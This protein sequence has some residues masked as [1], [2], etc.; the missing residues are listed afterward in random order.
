MVKVAPRVV[1]SGRHF[2]ATAAF[3]AKQRNFDEGVFLRSGE[4]ECVGHAY[5]LQ[6]NFTL[7]SGVKQKKTTA[8]FSAGFLCRPTYT[9]IEA[10]V[11]GALLRV[12]AQALGHGAAAQEQCVRGLSSSPPPSVHPWAI[13]NRMAS[14]SLS[15]LA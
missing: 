2:A 7:S 10:R 9:Y 14:M 8:G 3:L 4:A 6:Q 5:T 12:R 1:G 11:L 15:F 13:K